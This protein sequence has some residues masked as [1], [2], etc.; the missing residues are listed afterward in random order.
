MKTSDFCFEL[1][2]ELIAQ[3]PAD[4]REK[5]RLMVLDREAQTW[6]HR[7]FSDLPDILP[8]DALMVFNDSRVRKMRIYGE[9]RGTGGK[10]EFLLVRSRTPRLW[11]SLC[12]KSKKQFPGKTYDFPG[13]MSAV[14][15]GSL[16]EGLKLL[17][18]SSEIDENWLER[19][20]HMPL[21]PYI[22]RGDNPEDQS[23]YQTVYARTP[24][25]M[26]APTAGL[27]F[28]NDILGK[29]SGKGIQTEHVTLHVGLGTFL[30]VRTEYIKD[31]KMHEEE[32]EI[33]PGTA[34]R[35]ENYLKAG[36]R[37]VA[38]GTTSVRTLESAWCGD[39]FK[40]G[41]QRTSIFISPGYEFK[42]IGHLLTNFHT[43]EST[44]LMLV[45]AFAGRDFIMAAYNEAVRERYRFF[46]YGDAMLIL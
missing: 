21:P 14:L 15:S 26:A 7:M 18:F 34:Q 27:H 32:Y 22:R 38:V 33:T 19:Y 42:T 20:G 4:S 39:S 17:E 43:P 45:S 44:L 10:V 3:K 8:S 37:L 31:H 24:G 9:T 5:S 1:P 13:G 46:S 35:L 40:Q 11:E 29:L 2:E 6:R 36:K 23:R 28:T 12:R 25:S 16:P 41:R 30:P